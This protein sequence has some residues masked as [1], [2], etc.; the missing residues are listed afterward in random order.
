MQT[1]A[2]MASSK[3]EAQRNEGSLLGM[4]GLAQH[5]KILSELLG[6]HIDNTASDWTIR[7]L[8]YEL[9]ADDFDGI[10]PREI[11]A[12]P[13]VKRSMDTL[14]CDSKDLQYRS[15]NRV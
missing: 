6:T 5:R 12:Q 8:L 9:N 10:L 14:M 4:E 15:N 1:V 7:L 13:D 2:I 11:A 3:A